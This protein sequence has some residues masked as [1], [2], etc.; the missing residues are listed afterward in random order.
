MLFC[1]LVTKSIGTTTNSVNQF[2]IIPVSNGLEIAEHL[3]NPEPRY[4]SK[5]DCQIYNRLSTYDF[6]RDVQS[7]CAE[8]IGC[9]P[10]HRIDPEVAEGARLCIIGGRDHKRAIAK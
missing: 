5:A 8:G 10:G 6:Y 1:P 7:P 2:E 3:H 4:C 9:G